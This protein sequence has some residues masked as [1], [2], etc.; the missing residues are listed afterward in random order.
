[1][2]EKLNH[3]SVINSL[4][5]L[6]ALSVCIYHFVCTTTGFV[7]DDDVLNVFHYGSKGVQVFFII[8]GIVIPLSMIKSGYSFSLFFKF[9][10]KR[11]TRIEPPYIG[12]VIIGIIYLVVRNYIPSSTPIDLTPSFRDVLLHIGYLVPF[13]EDAKWINPVFW[14]L[15]IEFQYYLF[16]AVTFP[17]VLTG[18]NIFR[19]LFYVIVIGLPLVFMSG[20]A[21]FTYWS[22][23]FSL[24]IFY[25]LLRTNKIKSLEYFIIT[26]ITSAV[27]A[28]NQGFLDLFIGLGTLLVINQFSNFKNRLGEFFGNISYSVYLLHSII[29]SAF[30]NFM[31]HKVT[32]PLDKLIVII[33]GI[34]ITIV[35]SYLYWRVIEKPSQ[36]LAQRIK[37]K[38]IAKH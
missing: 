22:P 5:G 15:S 12:V 16:L 7:T 25:I 38:K 37:F 1:M 32:E 28:Y 4:R 10:L 6:A 19:I 24:G 35:A 8:S 17:L 27:I 33:I 18:K 26:I 20:Q 29:G 2:K 9:I 30:I 3:I 31:S 34:L 13:F 21:F 23:Y 36:K 14:T 11:F